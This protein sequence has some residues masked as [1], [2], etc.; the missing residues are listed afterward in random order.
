[1]NIQATDTLLRLTDNTYLF[2][3]YY[4]LKGILYNIQ[5]NE[6]FKLA[7]NNQYAVDYLDANGNAM[8]RYLRLTNLGTS[9]VCCFIPYDLY[10]N[11]VYFG[12]SNNDPECVTLIVDFSDTLSK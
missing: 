12:T 5:P 4:R 11:Q 9:A 8:S 7:F 2:P 10:I 1:M 3:N 6:G